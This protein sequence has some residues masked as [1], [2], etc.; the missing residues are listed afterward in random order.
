M[1]KKENLIHY[2]DCNNPNGIT[3]IN[4]S[5]EEKFVCYA[6][7]YTKALQLLYYFQERGVNRGE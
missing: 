6:D 1:K 5:I 3:F 4:T 7:L 2:F